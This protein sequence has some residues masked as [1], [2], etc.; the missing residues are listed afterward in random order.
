M[1]DREHVARIVSAYA[2]RHALAP[3]QLPALIATVHG[4]LVGIEG[5][6]PPE[7]AKFL[8]PAV[9]IRRSVQPDAITCLDCGRHQRVLKRH[10]MTAHQLTVDEYRKRWGLKSDYPMVAPNSTADANWRGRLAWGSEV[11]GRDRTALM[12][13]LA[14]GFPLFSSSGIILSRM[15]SQLVLQF[16]EGIVHCGKRAGARRVIDTPHKLVSDL[17]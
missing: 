10:L 9:P 6:E 16:V 3:D 5:G 13:A 1:P 11:E 4:A 8:A 15:F 17:G 7:P 12:A 2:K 14:L